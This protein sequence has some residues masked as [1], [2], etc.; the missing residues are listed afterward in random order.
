[1]TVEAIKDLIETL[2]PEDL[3]ALA[4]WISERESMAWDRQIE[5]D[6]SPGGAGMALLDEVDAQIRAGN[7][8]LFKV[9]PKP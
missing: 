5:Q 1:M 2:P 3:T 6:F 8:H 9:T 4:Y 7:G